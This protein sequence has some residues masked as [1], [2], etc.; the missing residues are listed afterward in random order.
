MNSFSRS[1]GTLIDED[2]ADEPSS[3][4]CLPYMFHP[5]NNYTAMNIR[6]EENVVRMPSDFTLYPGTANM[7]AAPSFL[8]TAPHRQSSYTNP[9]IVSSHS[10]THEGLDLCTLPA[11]SNLH[12]MGDDCTYEIPCIT[13]ECRTV[14]TCERG[15]DDTFS[16]SLHVVRSLRT[17][18]T[19]SNLV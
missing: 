9:H 2:C 11:Q 4:S 6:E 17:R 14:R 13:M 18:Q 15:D 1:R 3:S 7:D 19:P 12:A 8:P 10:N 5:C 16:N